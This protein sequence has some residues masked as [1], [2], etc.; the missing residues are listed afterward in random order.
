MTQMISID[1]MMTRSGVA[2][3][4]SGARRLVSAMTD[5]VCFTY[6]RQALRS[7]PVDRSGQHPGEQQQC[8]GTVGHVQNGAAHAD[9]LT[10]RDRA[11]Q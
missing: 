10:L 1:E 2:F 9:R 4:T 5:E 8:G 7:G 3:G 6:P 11:D